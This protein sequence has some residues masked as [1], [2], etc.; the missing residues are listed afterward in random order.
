MTSQCFYLVLLILALACGEQSAAA[1]PPGMLLPSLTYCLE[2]IARVRFTAA[3]D[4]KVALREAHAKRKAQLVLQ[5][6]DERCVELSSRHLAHSARL[7]SAISALCSPPENT[8]IYW[9]LS[10]AVFR[11]VYRVLSCQ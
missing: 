2:L 3:I 6:P 4:W 7:L 8:S 11:I 1:V 10:R 5:F 9:C